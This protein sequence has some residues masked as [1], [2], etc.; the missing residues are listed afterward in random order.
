[1]KAANGVSSTQEDYL[2]AILSLVETNGSARARD[3]AADVSVHKSTVTAAL[4]ALAEKGLVHYAPYELVTLTDSGREIAERVVRDH[5]AIRRFLREV[6]LVGEE[7][8]EENACRMEHVMDKRVLERLVDFA[9]YM[10]NCRESVKNCFGRYV[11]NVERQ[12]R[13]ARERP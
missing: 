5:E 11:K 4:R 1:M 8:A 9:D 13:R 3:I 6:L 12:A 7:A 2:E 10:K